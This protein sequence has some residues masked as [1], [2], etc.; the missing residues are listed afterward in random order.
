MDTGAC[1][2]QVEQTRTDPRPVPLPPSSSSLLPSPSLSPSSQPRM[3]LDPLY[4]CRLR[5]RCR[6]LAQLLCPLR[7][8][9]PLWFRH[10]RQ[11][12]RRRRPLPRVYPQLVQ[13]PVDAP[14]SLVGGRSSASI[15]QIVP[16]STP[17][18]VWAH[19]GRRLAHL[20]GLPRQVL[21]R[22]DSHRD[23][24]LP[25]HAR[26]QLGLA[27]LDVHPW[28]AHALPVGDPLLRA[29]D[30]RVAQVPHCHWSRR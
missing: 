30:A 4:W 1:R 10:G 22:R 5:S 19:A 11:P 13:L 16:R 6:R 15:L 27:V 26:E 9:R 21:V 24:R 29:A 18:D 2:A 8:P 20:L 3:E 12:P 14:V 7:P 28:R 17:A 25:M 23:R